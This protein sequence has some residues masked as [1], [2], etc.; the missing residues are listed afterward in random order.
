MSYYVRVLSLSDGTPPVARLQTALS[1]NKLAAKL[2]IDDGTNEDWTQLLLCHEDGSEIAVI[3]R[4]AASSTDLVEAEIQ[5]FLDEIA[6][7]KPPSAAEWLAE[8]FPKV[9]TI[10]A[11]QL[12][13]GTDVKNGWEIL[14]TVKDALHAHVRGIIQAD[15]EGFS[16]E[17]G[18]HILW[19]FADSVTGEWWMGVLQNGKWVHFQMDLGNKNHREAFLLGKVPKGVKTIA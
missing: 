14:G 9:R 13:H 6:D 17:E 5:E 12:L 3:E 8:Y 10:Y 1:K 4:N 16:N 19:Q 7:C 18:F 15:G 2:S 11:F